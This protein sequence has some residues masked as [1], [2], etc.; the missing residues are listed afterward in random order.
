MG[1]YELDVRELPPAQ[2][3]PMIMKAFEELDRGEALTL[4]NDHEPKPLYHQ[5]KSEIESFDAEGYDVTQESGRKF[6]AKFP[7]Q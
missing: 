4:V 1:E 6:V 2:R 3:H 7:K 5:M